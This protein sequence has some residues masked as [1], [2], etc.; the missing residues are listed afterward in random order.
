MNQLIKL[1]IFNRG[2]ISRGRGGD[3]KRFLYYCIY[4][5]GLSILLTSLVYLIDVMD[6]V[7]DRF[8]PMI[9]LKRCWMQNSRWVEAF[10]VYTPIS[11]IMLINII[12]YSITAYRIFRVHQET[13]VIRTGESQKHSEADTDRYY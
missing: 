1:I 8:L 13:S 11:I 12:L 7:P 5:F 10:Y 4:A 2:G 6:L 9:G 3:S